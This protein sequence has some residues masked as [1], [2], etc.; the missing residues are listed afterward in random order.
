V[1]GGQIRDPVRIAFVGK[2]IF[3]ASKNVIWQKKIWLNSIYIKMNRKS[4]FGITHLKLQHPVDF[5]VRNASCVV[6][7]G[8]HV[9]LPAMNILQ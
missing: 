4:V 5:L 6:I 9:H 3:N 8:F 2:N 7:Y 1:G